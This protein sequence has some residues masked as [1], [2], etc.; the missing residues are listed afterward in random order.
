VLKKGPVTAAIVSACLIVLILFMIRQQSEDQFPLPPKLYTEAERFIWEE[1]TFH[2]GTLK[3]MLKPLEKE[4]E[5]TLSESL[6]LSMT[7]AIES[8]NH[9]LFE[10][11]YYLLNKYFVNQN[12]LIY[13]KLDTKGKP[14]GNTNALIDDLRIISSLLDGYRIWK[15]QEYMDTAKEL[16]SGLLTYCTYQNTFIDFYDKKNKTKSTSLTIPYLDITTMRE[17]ERLGWINKA[18]L[19]N[20]EHVATQVEAETKIFFPKNYQV[21]VKTFSYEDEVNMFEQVYTAY[22]LSR[23]GYQTDR[24][25]HFIKSEFEK[26]KKLYGR[27]SIHSKSPTVQHESPALYAVTILYSLSMQ[28]NEFANSLYHR[29]QQFQAQKPPYIGVYMDLNTTNT[30]IFDNLFPLIVDRRFSRNG[31]VD[32]EK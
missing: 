4:G 14:L 26:N 13:W 23:A 19:T 18:V 3:T 32:G 24:F 9:S 11:G 22:H 8:H 7:Y 29:M 5:Y 21:D 2:N 16:T 6:G 27:Y 25:Y 28:D 12:K 31:V 10:N 15:K 20:M 1:M 17:L 30:H